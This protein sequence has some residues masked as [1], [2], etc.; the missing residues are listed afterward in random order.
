MGIVLTG[1]YC[2]SIHSNSEGNWYIGRDADNNF[3]FNGWTTG[4]HD[5]DGRGGTDVLTVESPA[6]CLCVS[7]QDVNGVVTVTGN[8]V[9]FKLTNFEKIVFSD[10]EVK[11]ADATRNDFFIAFAIGDTIDGQDSIDTVKYLRNL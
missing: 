10:R 4:K 8:N 2:C 9:V 5:L 3:T 6:A 11:L 1:H 7:T